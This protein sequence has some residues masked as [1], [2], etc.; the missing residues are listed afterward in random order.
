MRA[1]LSAIVVFGAGF[2]ACV[3]F[4]PP[5]HPPCPGPVVSPP[6]ASASS[7]GASPATLS[8]TMTINEDQTASD[9]K[10]KVTLLFSSIDVGSNN[11]VEFSHGETVTCNNDGSGPLQFDTNKSAYVTRVGPTGDYTCM[12]QQNSRSAPVLITTMPGR[13]PIPRGI[14]LRPQFLPSNQS[15]L[16]V[17]YDPNSDP[18]LGKCLVEIDANG[19]QIIGSQTISSAPNLPDNGQY[20]IPDISGLSGQGTIVIT[21]TCRSS[22][23]H[24]QPTPCVCQ[25]P[26]Q[27]ESVTVI[28]KTT[29]TLDM[30]WNPTDP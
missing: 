5:S 26:T 1:I 11:C 16:T 28:Y 27:F 9:G 19:S 3:L 15:R 29:A 17:T 6:D 23:Q 25:T 7:P 13:T 4:F 12:Y 24:P 20:T 14:L 2:L 22:A 10:S 18:R 30:S 8:V 21:R